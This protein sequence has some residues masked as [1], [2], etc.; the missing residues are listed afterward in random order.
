VTVRD[1]E[2][3]DIWPLIENA[4]TAHAVPAELLL[5]LVEA[6]SGRNPRAVRQG[7]WPDW[8][9]GYTQLTVETA[10][11]FGIGDGTPAAWE[12]VRDALFDRETSLSVGA[13]MLTHCLYLAGGDWLQAL[14]AYNS[15]QPQAEGNWWW[16]RWAA[17]VA[18]Y[19]R[20][21]AWARET[22]GAG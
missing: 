3:V 17:N 22:V 2:G 6:E 9:A 13:Q 7:P 8:S 5:A 16:Q 15:G 19:R 10:A 21:L 1:T 20:A 11:G 12:T 14:I 4:A 18:T